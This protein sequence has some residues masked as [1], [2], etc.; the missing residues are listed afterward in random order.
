MYKS[1]LLVCIHITHNENSSKFLHLDK[2]W[3]TQQEMSIDHVNYTGPSQ[4]QSVR[5]SSLDIT[6][7][8]PRWL[9]LQENQQ[10]QVQVGRT[11]HLTLQHFC[12]YWRSTTTATNTPLLYIYN[13]SQC[14]THHKVNAK[15]LFSP[16]Y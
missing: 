15:W 10:V 6:Q 13:L 14:L 9:Q 2:C 7:N 5:K 3:N 8:L 4:L 12:I 1:I 16:G 11:F